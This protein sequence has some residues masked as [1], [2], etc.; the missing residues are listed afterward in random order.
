MTRAAVNRKIVISPDR[1]ASFGPGFRLDAG[2]SRSTL[3]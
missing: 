2:E 1:V 3:G